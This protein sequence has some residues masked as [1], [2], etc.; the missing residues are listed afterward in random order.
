MVCRGATSLDRCRA[1]ECTLYWTL[2][3]A[4][5]P[6][7]HLCSAFGLRCA[8]LIPPDWNI[9][10]MLYLNNRVYSCYWDITLLCFSRAPSE[11]LIFDLLFGARRRARI[12]GIASV[13]KRLLSRCSTANQEAAVVVRQRFPDA[14]RRRFLHKSR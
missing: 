10:D 12:P 3:S 13:A 7:H 11:Q 8:V 6:L 2:V 9:T 14:C 1:A 4:K 5:C